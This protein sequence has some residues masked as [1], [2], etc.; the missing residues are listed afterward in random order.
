MKISLKL[1]INTLIANH[2]E[3]R[4][5]RRE[6]CRSSL[7]GDLVNRDPRQT[8]RPLNVGNGPAMRSKAKGRR[9]ASK[10]KPQSKID[11]K[12]LP[13][14]H[15]GQGNALWTRPS[16]GK[17]VYLNCPIE[18]CDRTSFLH[19]LAFRNHMSHP[20]GLHK[21]KQFS[22]SN[23]H[24]IETY[25]IVAPGQERPMNNVNL[26]PVSVAS[27]TSM[28][29]VDVLTPTASG[30]DDETASGLPLGSQ[31]SVGSIERSS[32]S[33][34]AHRVKQLRRAHQA[35]GVQTR[36]RAQKA[37]QEFDRDLSEESDDSDEDEP[38]IQRIPGNRIDQHRAAG[39]ESPSSNLPLNQGEAVDTRTEAS[40]RGTD[41]VAQQPVD[42]A[43]KEERDGSPRF[44]ERHLVD[45]PKPDS[46]AAVPVDSGEG[47]GDKPLTLTTDALETRKRAASE[48][49]TT[50]PPS[51]KRSRTADLS[52]TV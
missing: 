14:A 21:L 51:S 47:A 41:M 10:S 50:P 3:L 26:P 27:P 35:I 33:S 11:H 45:S 15:D 24:A 4:R 37:A 2:Q 16:D 7:T 22:K 42:P 8:L 18:G 20:D 40:N 32:T 12:G 43:L 48:L 39:L 5:Q 6:F 23:D 13:T 28:R 49:P 19:I 1:G 44:E 31:I 38:P 25:G 52:R 30:S 17:L 9:T 46:A 36:S 29:R 34:E